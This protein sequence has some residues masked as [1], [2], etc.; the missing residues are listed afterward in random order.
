MKYGLVIEVLFA[1]VAVGT[2]ACASHPQLPPVPKVTAHP[3][4]LDQKGGGQM[5]IGIDSNVPS[6]I[7]AATNFILTATITAQST[8]HDLQYEWILPKGLTVISGSATGAIGDLHEAATIEQKITLSANTADNQ[9]IHLHV[10]RMDGGEARG[11]MVQFNT[12]DQA[13][14]AADVSEKAESAIKS[15]RIPANSHRRIMQ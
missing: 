13:K 8:L 5:Q 9:K 15:R 11:Q 7:P 14:I 4:G 3:Y 1:L 10:F 2:I 6:P 12:R